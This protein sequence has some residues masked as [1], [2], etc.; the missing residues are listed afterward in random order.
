MFSYGAN[1][2]GNS[3]RTQIKAH[4]AEMKYIELLGS[5]SRFLRKLLQ[6]HDDSSFVKFEI[7][8]RL[9]ELRDLLNVVANEN[10]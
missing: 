4:L 1:A 3:Q 8:N 6:K 5:E 10:K 2:S 7:E 9:K